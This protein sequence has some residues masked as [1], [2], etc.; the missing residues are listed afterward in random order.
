MPR[1]HAWMAKSDELV[2][3]LQALV[4]R[5]K[6]LK[7]S[8]ATFVSSAR[9]SETA[10][11]AAASKKLDECVVLARARAAF[12][13]RTIVDKA[14][15]VSRGLVLKLFARDNLGWAP[16]EYS[17]WCKELVEG[18]DAQD[19]LDAMFPLEPRKSIAYSLSHH[20]ARMHDG[21]VGAPHFGFFV[22]DRLSFEV[23]E[24]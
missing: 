4:G 8:Y 12:A 10:S 21:G 2:A 23:H 24:F 11:A 15:A 20:G 7:A 17:Q 6:D 13:Q 16:E 14:E 22:E 5:C 9:P 18:V 1:C 19:K 3:H